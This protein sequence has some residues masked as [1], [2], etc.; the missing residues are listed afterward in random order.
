MRATSVTVAESD[1]GTVWTIVD[2][3]HFYLLTFTDEKYKRD[4][5]LLQ[6]IHQRRILAICTA[7]LFFSF[8]YLFQ[9]KKER[10]YII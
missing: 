4:M 9:R 10:Q 3:S 1:D 5:E 2:G 7:L 8:C 6:K